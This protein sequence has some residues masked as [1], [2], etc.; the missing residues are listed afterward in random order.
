MNRIWLHH[1]GRGLA[2]TPGDFGMLGERPTHP[3]LLDWLADEFMSSGW[4]LK[5][6]HRLI[7]GSNAYRQSSARRPKLDAVDPENR[8]L[9]RMSIRRL[10]AETLRDSL[11][12]LSGK[13]T[14][15]LHGPPTPVSPDLIGQIILAVDTRDGAARPT[16][17]F[18]P[19]GADEFRRSIYV[20]VRRSMPLSLMA[21]FDPPALTPNCDR[22]P[23]SNTA[24]QALLMMNNPFVA[25]QA[26]SL[27]ARIQRETGPDRAAQFQLAWRTVIGHTPSDTQS[28]RGVAFLNAEIAA[29][30][31]GEKPPSN[32]ARV[33]LTRLCQAL[34]SSNGFLYVE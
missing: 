5:R 9:G 14:E 7:L 33:A 24:L 27:A 31:K 22:R 32:P 17:K 4:N 34:L 16:G 25:S 21:P 3:E 23:S 11:L 19:L 28:E 10:E 13:L 1:F 15:R 18:V 29:L 8:L 26:Q 6:L 12:A 20:Q 2:A 30:T